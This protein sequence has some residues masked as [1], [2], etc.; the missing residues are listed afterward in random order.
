MGDSKGNKH[1]CA[2]CKKNANAGA[3]LKQFIQKMEPLKI[4]EPGI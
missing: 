1:P 2:A 4:F 3:I